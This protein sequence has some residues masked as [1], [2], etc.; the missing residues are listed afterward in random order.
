MGSL[1]QKCSKFLFVLNNCLQ[2]QD[3][4]DSEAT[5]PCKQR[6]STT[7]GIMHMFCC[8]E[9]NHVFSCWSCDNQRLTQGCYFM[10]FHD[11]ID[12]GTNCCIS[13]HPVPSAVLRQSTL[14]HK[15]LCVGPLGDCGDS[16]RVGRPV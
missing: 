7:R 3:S 16:A 6:G 1:E 15:N 4:H 8:F 10:R 14:N 11:L 12:P 2:L 13:C 5:R 9:Y